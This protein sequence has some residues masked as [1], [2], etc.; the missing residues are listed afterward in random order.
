MRRPSFFL[1]AFLF[2][3]LSFVPLAWPQGVTNGTIIGIIH[4][5][6]GTFPEPVLVNL[7][8]HGATIATTYTDQE[9]RFG[10]YGLGSSSYHVI[11]AD[12]RYVPIN[13][14]V[15]I[16]PDVMSTNV[17]QLTLVPREGKTVAQPAAGSY[18]VGAADLAK[19]YPKSAVKEYER[20]VKTEA[21]GKTDEAIEHYRKAIN[22]APDFAM[23]HN[24]LGTLLIG[25]SQFPDAQKELEQSIRLAPGDPKPCFNLANLMLLTGKLDDAEKYLQDGFR[26]QPD[27]AFGFFVQGSVL[28]R[29]GKLPDAERALQRALQL[30]P[31]MPRPH[32]ELV[33]LYLRQRRSSDAMSELQKFLQVAPAD[34]LAPKARQILQKLQSGAPAPR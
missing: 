18:V 33:N 25:K 31:K 6:R 32:L 9:G 22:S 1:F 30:D 27:S 2:L 15:E 20:G 8:L 4:V 26:K 19:N 13:V 5:F 11:I 34:P 7:Q 10:F 24:N 28:E 3:L 21:E 16:R 23:A 14:T 17:L 29:S 12:E